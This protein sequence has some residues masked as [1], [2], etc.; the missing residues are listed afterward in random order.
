M[1]G[2]NQSNTKPVSD[3]AGGDP[4]FTQG[5]L[6]TLYSEIRDSLMRYTN[7]YTSRPHEIEDVVQESFVKVLESLRER[8]IQS[9][10]AYLFRTA[11]HLALNEQ[12]RCANKLTD[13]IGDILPDS[14]LCRT[15][16]LEEQYES[17]EKFEA[18]CHAV[19]KLPVKC[20]RV[21]VMRR[22][23]GFSQKEIAQE[24]DISVK[25]VEAHLTKALF[26]CSEYMGALD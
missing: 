25:T 18:F 20:R 6:G 9:P 12:N 8:D 14:V 2:H 15:V 5:D 13:S 19:R 23:Y 22:V 16:R 17:T 26:L 3:S 4:N 1:K 7:G 11:K 10:R 24:L 21:F